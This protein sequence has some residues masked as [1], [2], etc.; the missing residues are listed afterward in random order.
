MMKGIC[1]FKFFMR[2]IMV[3]GIVNHSLA[4]PVVECDAYNIQLIIF[5]NKKYSSKERW[6]NI[7]RV[8]DV[9]KDAIILKTPAEHAI[10]F[11]DIV[12]EENGTKKAHD[13]GI[14]SFPLPHEHHQQRIESRTSKDVPEEKESK[15]DALA[16]NTSYPLSDQW[17]GFFEKLRRNG[18]TPLYHVRWR[19]PVPNRD[20]PVVFSIPPRPLLVNGGTLSGFVKISK[21]NAVHMSA[22]LKWCLQ[23]TDAWQKNR[24]TNDD[25]Q[26]FRA[27][28]QYNIGGIADNNRCFVMETKSV[29]NSGKLIYMDSSA[30]GI[31]VYMEEHSFSKKLE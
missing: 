11:S 2:L 4:M 3:G 23:P 24:L 31:L 14:V 10:G 15:E 21:K 5:S 28:D 12:M 8:L 19:M 1:F 30:L 9:P 7:S 29:L 13:D 27:L 16:W 6:L 18:L 17:I 20:A 26:Q 25:L 22:H